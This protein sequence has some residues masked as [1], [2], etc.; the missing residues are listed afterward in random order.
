M[1][2][3]LADILGWEE[4]QEYEYRSD[5]VLML[6]NGKIYYKSDKCSSGWCNYAFFGNEIED[7]RRAKKA[8]K[9]KD[10]LLDELQELV[11]SERVNKIIKQLREIE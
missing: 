2:K 10:E 11:S 5:D 3:T 4:G 6:D 8:K 9:T 1:S 7:L